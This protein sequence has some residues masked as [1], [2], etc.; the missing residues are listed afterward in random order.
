MT[1]ADARNADLLRP[2]YSNLKKYA[3]YRRIALPDE[4]IADAVKI[5]EETAVVTEEPL[6]E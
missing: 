5:A 4:V 2:P 3:A 1:R 6:E